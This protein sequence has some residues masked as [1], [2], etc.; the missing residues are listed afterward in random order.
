MTKNR[1]FSLIEIMIALAVSVVALLSFLT[2]FTNNNNHAVGSRNRSVA[3]LLAESLMDD[4]DAH[5]YGNPEPLRW[6]R[7][8]EDPVSVWVSG[9]EQ[10]MEFHKSVTYENGSFVGQGNDSSDLVTITLSWREGFGN[11]QASGNQ[12][13]ELQVRVPVWR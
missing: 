13:K 7:E 1:G 8:T 3:I 6:T 5:T 2:V 11:D 12:N 9:R 10:K 4:I